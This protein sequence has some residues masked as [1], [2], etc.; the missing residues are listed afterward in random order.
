MTGPA[1]MVLLAGLMAQ[2]STGNP[3]STGTLPTDTDV[4]AP[5]RTD[6][7]V[8]GEVVQVL[9]GDTIRVKMDDGSLLTV[10]M[11][12]IDAP[13]KHQPGGLLAQHILSIAIYSKKVIVYVK[14]F[15][16][17]GRALGDVV[18]LKE[19]KSVNVAMACG[20]FAWAAE[21]RYRPPAAIRMC[22]DGA[23]AGK[24]GIWSYRVKHVEPWKFRRKQR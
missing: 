23:R 6:T 12:G 4:L 14:K 15:D 10:R 2:V 5:M 1:A 21:P 3:A 24:L 18:G 22:V 16:L 13:E 19:R 20:G 9:D 11:V 17:Y 7:P 8:I